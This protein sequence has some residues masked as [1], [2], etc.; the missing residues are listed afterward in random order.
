MGDFSR[1]KAD[2]KTLSSEVPAPET[3]E[4]VLLHLHNRQDREAA[5]VGASL[6]E[7]ALQER[8]LRSFDSADG[9]LEQ[10]LFE[11]RGP[12]SDFNSKILVAQA[13]AVIPDRSAEDLQR[14]RKIRNCFA[15]ARVE[16]GFEEP[17]VAKEV[18][19]L[20]AAVAVRS[21]MESNPDGYPPN[22]GSAK[23]SFGLSCYITYTMLKS[24]SLAAVM[25]GTT[26]KAPEPTTDL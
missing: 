3:V 22:Y 8:L 20:A 4:H 9:G 5:I 26:T 25:S 18:R 11:N 19:E 24:E 10:N 6:V 2:V 7:S 17:L 12:L 15:H 21:V 23:T 16:V 13:F 14:I 1:E